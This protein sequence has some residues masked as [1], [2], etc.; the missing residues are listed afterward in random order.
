[1]PKLLVVDDEPEILEMVTG[2]FSLRGYQVLKAQDGLEGLKLAKSECP[3]VILLDL[4][5]KEMDGD[6]FLE[7]IRE[8]KIASKVL[9]ITGYQDKALHEKIESLGVEGII[10]KP[11]SLKEL[12]RKIQELIPS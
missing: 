11:V 10:E 9:V 8:E 6:R 1:M 12:Q 4:K 5:M 3:D 2:H 7:K